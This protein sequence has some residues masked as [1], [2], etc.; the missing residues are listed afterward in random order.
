[1]G[2]LDK[3][4]IRGA[5]NTRFNPGRNAS[6]DWNEMLTTVENNFEGLETKA[7]DNATAIA[8]NVTNIATNTTGIADHESRLASLEAKITAICECLNT[9]EGF[10]CAACPRERR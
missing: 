10:E 8:T 6:W 3:Y 4:R 2:V 1:M 5:V 9:I 7:N